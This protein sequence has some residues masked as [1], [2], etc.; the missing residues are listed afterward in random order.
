MTPRSAPVVADAPAFGSTVAGIIP[1]AGH[2]VPLPT[3][4]WLTVA[5]IGGKL[6]D[7]QATNAA[8]LAQV[9]GGHATAFVI[10]TGAGAPGQGGN[11]FP[12]FPGCEESRNLYSRIFVAR[13]SGEQACWSVDAAG[14]PWGDATYR[15]RA[16]GVG[17]L[18]QRGAAL[19]EVVLRTRFLRANKDHLLIYE[20][21]QAVD[22]PPEGTSGWDWSH[23]MGAPDRLA[24]AT[25][26]RDW[27]AAWWPLVDRGFSGQL[28]A[29]YAKSPP[30]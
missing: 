26:V 11:G 25:Q 22:V 12:R 27:A 1:F 23:V 18:R 24:R 20:L 15:I 6:P 30:F 16:A 5:A 29:V 17:E 19:P 9:T 8:M 7:G 10:L 13:P 3:G 2:T 4:D 21:Y 14:I 28:Q